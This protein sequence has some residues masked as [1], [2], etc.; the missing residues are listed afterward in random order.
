[1]HI[2][3]K[4]LILL[5]SLLDCIP[6]FCGGDTLYY[7]FYFRVGASSLDLSY[8]DNGLRLD[9]LLS[10]IHSR[11]AHAVL[12][13]VSLYSSASPEGGSALNKRLSDRRLA[14]LRTVIQHRLAIPD[15]ILISFSL[16]EDWDGLSSL[17]EG[18]DIPYRG[19]VLRILRDTPVWVIRN[20]IVVD[21][22]KRQL[23][24]LRGG[25]VWR[26]MHEHFFPE[27]RNSSVIECEFEPF[28]AEND[29]VPDLSQGVC[30]PDTV[31]LRDTVERAIMMRDTVEVPVP[32][33][34]I[35]KPF[36]MGLKTNLL[37]DALLVPNIGVEFY[38]GKGWSLGGNWMY[39]WWNNDRRHRYWRVYGGEIGL[40]KYFAP[41][42]AYTPFIGHHVGLYGQML[43]YDFEFGGKGY[44]GGRP[45]GSLWEK[46]NYGFGLE[47]GYSL[48]IGRRLNLDFSLGVGYLGGTYYEYA[49]MDGHYVWEATK[50]RRWFG[51]TKAEVSLV[52]LLGRGNYNDKKGGRR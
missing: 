19:E 31:I 47:Y 46:S 3:K 22:R 49:P 2:F 1:M 14:S 44:M 30:P 6:V 27:L 21:S 11:Q 26:Y 24:N 41:R 35:P 4:L 13:R 12:R 33:T 15:S 37:Y 16:G 32:I 45:G 9:S 20:G 25:R 51:P 52:W 7:R 43:T 50:N 38:L 42:A 39:A 29:D 48:A 23:M 28:V 10:A 17:V 36:Y 8:R 34:N 5:L 18:S 40:R